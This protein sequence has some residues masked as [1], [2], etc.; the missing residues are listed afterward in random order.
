MI[1]RYN[2]QTYD[3]NSRHASRAVSFWL[4]YSTNIHF[5]QSFIA[6]KSVSSSC[7]IVKSKHSIITRYWLS[8]CF[9]NWAHLSYGD[10]EHRWQIF[11]N[12]C[13]FWSHPK[14]FNVFKAEWLII[15][16]CWRNKSHCLDY[17][18]LIW[19]I[20]IFCLSLHTHIR[21]FR[22]LVIFLIRWFIRNLLYCYCT[23]ECCNQL[24]ALLLKE[25]Y[26]VWCVQ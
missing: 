19:D 16:M 20:C 21:W 13:F 8:I 5:R 4:R 15:W 2:R 7:F 1:S 3:R 6:R 9:T 12:T 11:E 10:H 26:W 18:M 22:A 24:T 23:V 25:V 17:G 14:L